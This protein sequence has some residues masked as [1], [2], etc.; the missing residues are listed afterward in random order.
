MKP[1]IVFFGEGLGEEFHDSVARD[2]NEVST[3]THT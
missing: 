3:L 1:D 2:K